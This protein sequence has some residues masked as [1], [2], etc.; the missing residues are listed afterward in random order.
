MDHFF[1]NVIVYSKEAKQIA[2]IKSDF[3]QYEKGK[4]IQKGESHLHNKE[5]SLQ[6]KFYKE[7]SDAI[8]NYNQVLLFGST[9]AKTELLNVLSNDNRFTEVTVT[10][11]NTDKLTSNEQIAFVNNCFYIDV[12]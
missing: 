8:V 1:A 6:S 4:I 2:T 12:K 3:N 7:I 5:Q 11:K 10:T 9:T